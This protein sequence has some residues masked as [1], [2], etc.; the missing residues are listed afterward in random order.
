MSYWCGINSQSVPGVVPMFYDAEPGPADRKDPCSFLGW[1]FKPH[2]LVED[3]EGTV[4]DPGGDY[5]SGNP[6]WNVRN[7]IVAPSN[8]LLFN[9]DYS[10][11]ELVLL[12]NLCGDETMTKPLLEGGDPHKELALKM[13]GAESY[14]KKRRGLAKIRRF[15]YYYGGIPRVYPGLV[16]GLTWQEEADVAEKIWFAHGGRTVL[17]DE[18]TYGERKTHMVPL[19][20]QGSLVKFM[21]AMEAGGRRYWIKKVRGDSGWVRWVEEQQTQA[22]NLGYLKSIGGR[23][24]RVGYW[25]GEFKYRSFADRTVMNRPVQGA[26]GDILRYVLVRIWNEIMLRKDWKD[27]EKHSK[28]RWVWTVHDEFC[29]AITEEEP[30][31]TEI[32]LELERV[33][34]GLDIFKLTV[35]LKI[36]KSFGRRL[37]QTFKFE[38]K[39]GLWVPKKR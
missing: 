38:R 17:V 34:T 9:P 7:Y 18:K 39:E 26:C 11:Q 30:L 19:D 2:P 15:R 12:A 4:L 3:G 8:M 23:I 25:Y 16:D 13:W 32:V 20:G 6:R 14:N 33:L 28:I 21:E 10:G 24:H 1:Q 29:W 22:E 5:E 35:P 37:G 36:D 27:L 31:F